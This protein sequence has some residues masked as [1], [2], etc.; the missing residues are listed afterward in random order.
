MLL[1]VLSST[2]QRLEEHT[3]RGMLFTDHL[4][5]EGGQ[6]LVWVSSVAYL[7]VTDTDSMRRA[8]KWALSSS[9]KLEPMKAF[10]GNQL[11]LQS[12]R[13]LWGRLGGPP[14]RYDHHTRMFLGGGGKLPSWQW[15]RPVQRAEAAEAPAECAPQGNAAN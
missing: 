6:A 10:R 15:L 8:D 7:E 4:L 1:I 13:E 11:N 12:R 5:G 9:A 3:D 14:G 2:G